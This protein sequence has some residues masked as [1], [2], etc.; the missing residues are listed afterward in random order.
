MTFFLPAFSNLHE[1]LETLSYIATIIGIVAIYLTVKGLK[2]DQ[3]KELNANKQTLVNNSVKILKAFSEKIIPEMS[4]FVNKYPVEVE[5]S[6]RKALEEVN[7]YIT[8]DLSKIDKL[9]KDEKLDWA[10]EMQAKTAAAAGQ[11]FNELEQISV[12]MNYDLVEPNLVFGPIHKVFLNFVSTN[13]DYLEFISSEDA[14]YENVHKLYE[15]WT[16]VERM[17]ILDKKQSA[18][19]DEKRKLTNNE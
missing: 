1:L 10:I 7:H 2:R 13:S 4:D 3:E 5:I 15:N 14:P 6:K 11:I 12:Y 16:K 19:N 17:R 8:D 9:P 18:L